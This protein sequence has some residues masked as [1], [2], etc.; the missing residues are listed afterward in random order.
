MALFFCIALFKYQWYITFFSSLI[1]EIAMNEQVI[2]KI[3][4]LINEKFYVGSTIHVKVRFREHRKQLRGNRHHSKHL[5]ASWNKYGEEKFVFEI[6]ERV[7][8]EKS[9]QDAED[10]WLTEHFGKPHC[11]NSGSSAKAP[12]RGVYGAAHPHFGRAVS[13]EQKADISRT[14]KEF[15][16]AAPENHPRFGTTHSEETKAK[17]SANRKGKMAGET[18]YRYG[19]TLSAE[20]REKIGVAQRGIKKGARVYTPEGLA[21]AQENMR[22]HAVTPTPKGWSEVYAKFP[23]GVQGRYDFSNAVYTGALTRITGVICPQHG[24]FSNYAARFRKGAGC[25]E[26][27]GVIRAAKKKQEMLKRWADP[28]FRSET[29]KSQ[30]AGRKAP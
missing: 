29:I 27:G 20:V 24:E 16:A 11:Y 17:I 23:A 5:Q 8:S 22:R 13:A 10:V 3:R 18:H 7:P 6:V 26:C 9:L 19:Q 1:S 21:R 4:N 12:F 2:Y 30:N 14:L 28:V 25:P 15:Y